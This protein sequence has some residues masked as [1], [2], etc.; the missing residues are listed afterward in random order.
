MA[1][2]L[3][4]LAA[5]A[6]SGPERAPGGSSDPGEP[7]SGA[8]WAP[9]AVGPVSRW[10][11]FPLLPDGGF[12]IAGWCA[13]PMHDNTRARLLE[14]RQAG[15]T[16]LLPA[17]EDPYQE[18]LNQERLRA[19]RETGLWAIVRDDRV[20]PDET[21]RPK[22][23][24]RVE[25]VVR[26]YGDSAAL[27]GYFLAD[28]PS[29]DL[30]ESLVALTTAFAELDP[31][32]PAYVNHLGLGWALKGH[33]GKTYRAY[34]EDFVAGVRPA[35]FSVDLY[36]L[37]RGRE[38]PNLCP[39]LDTARTVAHRLGSPFWAVL[40]LTPHL[41]FRDLSVG[42][43]SYQAML[44]LAYGAKGIVWFTYWTPVSGEFE[45]R[46][47][48]IAYS[49]ERTP[50]YQRVTEVNRRAGALGRMLAEREAVEV[51]HAGDLPA[52]GRPLDASLPLQA[53]EGGSFTIGFFPSPPDPAPGSVPDTLALLVSRDFRRAT[54]ARLTWRGRAELWDETRAAWTPYSG[55]NDPL[56]LM[57]G[58]AKLLR[59][60]PGD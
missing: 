44:A 25:A 21:H 9:S 6:C 46:G 5:A 4:M 49:G 32:H 22:W 43:I 54:E 18:D 1:A 20:H 17:L 14:Y 39:G 47:G 42:E 36:T 40:Q 15:F 37:L 24:R 3:A 29:P 38:T 27:L 35:F 10:P 31:R 12:P 13:P 7:A 30:T 45:Y 52:D 59:F 34:L 28:E 41:E 50:A 51:L 11:G 2:A 60:R 23:R 33:A 16:V 55:E 19:A 57:P 8:A 53:A 26:A 56:K 58:G 48:P